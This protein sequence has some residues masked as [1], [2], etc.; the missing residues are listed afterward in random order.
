VGEGFG[1]AVVGH[2]TERNENSAK[3]IEYHADRIA[4]MG[5]FDEVQAL[6]M[7]ED[8]EV[9]D[10]TDF[11]ESEDVVVVPLFIADG[12]HTQEDIPEDMGLT[13][14]YRE[15]C[16]T[17]SVFDGQLTL[18][19]GFVC[20]EPLLVDLLLQLAFHLLFA[21]M[22][23]KGQPFG[24]GKPFLFE[25][26]IGSL[27]HRMRYKMILKTTDSVDGIC[28][29]HIWLNFVDLLFDDLLNLYRIHLLQPAVRQV[30]HCHPS[31]I[32]HLLYTLH[33]FKTD[34]PHL[35]LA[36]AQAVPLLGCF[37]LGES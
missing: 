17:L 37:T 32:E 21:V 5:R 16:V 11:F 3:A 1:L 22:G 35:L 30:Q 26:G 14:D 7:D 19:A 33:L 18:Y 24:I 28:Y 29:N 20:I 27:D 25:F 4:E 6:F 15:G 31:Q 36:N 9:D 2:G 10:V 34:L 23:I 13:D 8:P 12:Y